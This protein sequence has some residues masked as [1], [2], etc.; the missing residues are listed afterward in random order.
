MNIRMD[1]LHIAANSSRDFAQGKRTRAARARVLAGQDLRDRVA[2]HGGEP[3]SMTQPE[4]ARF[5]QSESEGAA[6]VSKAAGIE[7]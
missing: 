2:K 4:F 3:M 7:P 6:Q 1:A 5:V